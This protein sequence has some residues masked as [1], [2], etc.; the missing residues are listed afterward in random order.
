MGDVKEQTVSVPIPV[1]TKRTDKKSQRAALQN[2]GKVLRA[3]GSGLEHIVKV[4][5]YLTNLARDFRPMNEAYGEVQ[6]S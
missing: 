3:S 6:T 2:L 1:K 5:V 4:N